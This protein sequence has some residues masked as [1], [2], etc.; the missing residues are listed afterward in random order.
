[1]RNRFDLSYV[2]R[3]AVSCIISSCCVIEASEIGASLQTLPVDCKKSIIEFFFSDSD[4][5]WQMKKEYS[6]L[7]RFACT[8][9]EF[10]IL[11]PSMIERHSKH[12]GLTP[13]VH[14]IFFKKELD[15]SLLACMKDDELRQYFEKTLKQLQY[16]GDDMQRTF[17][18]SRLV[19]YVTLTATVENPK[20]MMN[21]IV[22]KGTEVNKI[23]GY[24]DPQCSITYIHKRSFFTTDESFAWQAYFESIKMHSASDPAKTFVFWAEPRTAE[25]LIFV[26]QG[27]GSKVGIAL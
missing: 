8:N 3:L 19:N 18:L 27:S 7:V 14:Q 11:I 5:L 2:Y 25:Y 13:E 1:M 10:A 22:L 16:E 23:A 26:F 17:G 20:D 9:K 24:V 21:L 15:V 12:M 6:S 4:F